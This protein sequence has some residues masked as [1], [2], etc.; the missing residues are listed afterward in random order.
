MTSVSPTHRYALL[1]GVGDYSAFDAS[2]HQA[3]GTSDLAGATHDVVSMYRLCIALE[4]PP[5][6]IHVLLSP[7]D[8]SDP[9]SAFDK[10]SIGTSVQ[11]GAATSSEITAQVKWL[12]RMLEASTDDSG[13]PAALLTYS[14]H[15]DFADGHLAL[16]PSDV[17]QVAGAEDLKGVLGY[18]DLRALMT[19]AAAANL[20]VVL[21]CC[22]AGAASHEAGA[23]S[24]LTHRTRTAKGPV[25]RI[26]ERTIAASKVGGHSWVSTFDGTPHNAL[27]WA[28]KVVTDQWTLAK[29][30]EGMQLTASY[31]TVV[32]RVNA[33]LSALS[34]KQHVEFQG[35][36]GA[37]KLPFF[38]RGSKKRGELTATGPNR[39]RHGGQLEPGSGYDFTIYNIEV[40]NGNTV[41]L[42]ATAISVSNPDPNNWGY[43]SGQEYVCLVSGQWPPTA[44]TIATFSPVNGKWKDYATNPLSNTIHAL[45]SSSVSYG[46]ESDNCPLS[47]VALFKTDPPTPAKGYGVQFAISGNNSEYLLDWAGLWPSSGAPSPAPYFVLSSSTTSFDTTKAPKAANH[48]WFTPL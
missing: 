33:L 41:T 7:P 9:Q 47:G 36:D 19:D 4:I 1:I 43:Q 10:A 14:G 38:H 3:P 23:L 20:T 37:E 17:T 25:T 48:K 44:G 24:S 32:E 26:G 28:L 45:G 46:N 30:V 11:V 16:C 42:T 29:A 21:D 6:N 27:T 40:K 15:G 34:F 2:T 8:G 5:A 18:P 31:A 35:P 13:P 39:E 12:A 22:H